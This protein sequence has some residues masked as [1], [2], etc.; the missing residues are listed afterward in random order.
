MNEHYVVEKITYDRA[1]AFKLNQ[2]LKNY[3]FETEE[4]R[5]GL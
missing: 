2:E 1:N 5:Q 4:T 3:G